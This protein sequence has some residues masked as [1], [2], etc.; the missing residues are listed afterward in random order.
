MGGVILFARNYEGPEQIAEL[1]G[2]PSIINTFIEPVLMLLGDT[3]WRKHIML[4]GGLAI[5]VS[6]LAMASAQSFPVLLLAMILSAPASGAFATLA[7]ATLAALAFWA[8]VGYRWPEGLS[9]WKPPLALGNDGS[10]LGDEVPEVPLLLAYGSPPP[11]EIRSTVMC[12]IIESVLREWYL[13][14]QQRTHSA[15]AMARIES[16]IAVDERGQMVLPKE[17][18]DRA[19]IR[20]GDKLALIS[21][22][23]DG[24]LCCFTL[25]KADALAQR[26]AEAIKGGPPEGRDEILLASLEAAAAQADRLITLAEWSE[27]AEFSAI[28]IRRLLALAA[29]EVRTRQ[30]VM[31]AGAPAVVHDPA[32]LLAPAATVV[33]WGFTAAS[34]PTALMGAS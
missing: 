5:A 32:A 13:E 33:W 8:S 16:L 34:A 6:L 28:E 14:P 25:I 24:E 18:R 1:L 9:Y 30:R 22:Q 23:K 21:W 27:K 11:D 7:P 29:E 31:E 26:R 17:L 20:A 2:L 3:R 12:A 15:E 19:K 4:G 10:P